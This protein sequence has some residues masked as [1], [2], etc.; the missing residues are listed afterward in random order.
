MR[1]FDDELNSCPPTEAQISKK[2]E[3]LANHE[4]TLIVDDFSRDMPF[5]NV[6]HVEELEQEMKKDVK[7]GLLDQDTADRV[8]EYSVNAEIYTFENNKLIIRKPEM[9]NLEINAKEWFKNFLYQNYISSTTDVL[10]DDM[11]IKIDNNVFVDLVW[12]NQYGVKF[13]M[14][15][16]KYVHFLDNYVF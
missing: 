1:L 3:R 11:I 13:R 14:D 8:N 5:D 6:N 9:L 12:V 2:E 4:K 16:K 10:L 15:I 7:E